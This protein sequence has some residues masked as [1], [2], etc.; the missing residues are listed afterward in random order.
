MEGRL[1]LY[2]NPMSRAAI[3]RWML[4]EVGAD[5]ELVHLDFE[6]GENRR[7]DFLAINPMGKL[8][9]L[10]LPDGTVM[11]E[12]AAIA[13]HL[14][15]RYPDA[16]LAPAM[17]T[18][19]RA[20]YYR[21]L[22][23]APSCIEPAASEVMMRRDSAPLPKKS[24]GWGSYDDVIDTLESQ[25]SPGPYLTG[26]RFTAADLIIAA[27]LRWMTLFGAP[28]LETSNPIQAFIE[29]ATDRAAYRRSQASG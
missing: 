3:T 29:R 15:D 24:V 6:A 4:E 11:T 28:R 1:K 22:F 20:T 18:S 13:A 7:A 17:G 21:W 5:Y 19:E 10:V 14:A 2:Y 23:F 27:T 9:T 26:D 25:L 16:G 12:S 8:P